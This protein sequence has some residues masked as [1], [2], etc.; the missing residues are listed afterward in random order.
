MRVRREPIG[1][2]QV[3][4]ASAARDV[5]PGSRIGGQQIDERRELRRAPDAAN[6]QGLRGFAMLDA[7]RRDAEDAFERRLGPVDLAD[8]GGRKL[9]D[10]RR[11]RSAPPACR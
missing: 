10:A 1:G 5:G 9:V 7:E 4:T 6:H 2:S 3:I 8:V 11:G